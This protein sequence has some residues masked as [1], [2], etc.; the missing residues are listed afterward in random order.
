MSELTSPDSPEVPFRPR[1]RRRLIL[2]AVPIVLGLVGALFLWQFLSAGRKLK[3]VLA[4]TDRLDPGWRFEDILASQPSVPDGENSALTISAIKQKMPPRWPAWDY[5]PPAGALPEGPAEGNSPSAEELQNLFRNLSPPVL[6]NDMQL[7]ALRQEIARAAEALKIAAKL[8]DQPRGHFDIAWSK[9]YISTPLNSI[10]DAREVARFL[11]YEVLLRAQEGDLPGA[12]RAY[13]GILNTSRAIGDTPTLISLLVRLA[14]RTVALDQL[15]RILAQG[16]LTEVTL[17]GLQMELETEEKE[18]LMVFAAR[19]ERA[20]MEGFLQALQK[21]D[22]PISIL[23]GLAGGIPPSS[24][25]SGW[26]DLTRF[27]NLPG[28]VPF[29]RAAYLERMNKLVAICQLPEKDQ[30]DQMKEFEKSHRDAPPIARALL[31]AVVKC[32]Q[33]HWRIQARLRC[34]AAALAVERFRLQHGR[35]PDRLNDLVPALWHEVLL[36]PF[37][38]ASFRFR[39]D[40]EGVVV[41]SIGPDGKDDG[42]AFDTLNTTKDGTDF[43]FR[44]WDVARRR[45]PPPNK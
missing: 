2:F 9:D 22:V 11:N 23:N 34:A 14:I 7:K 38:G 20:L 24:G 18:S 10:L 4:E 33:A 1:R 3:Q 13:R 28:A 19:G 5:P 44:L 35:W 45:Q 43:G 21:G 26:L 40:K 41:Y 16:Q 12:V 32:L 29:N 31:P 8:A 17:A 25:K 36:D 30:L 6:L 42:G 15:E 39:R 27:L 37:D